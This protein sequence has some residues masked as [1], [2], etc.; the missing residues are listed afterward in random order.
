[1][2]TTPPSHAGSSGTIPGRTNAYLPPQDDPLGKKGGGNKGGGSGSGS[3]SGS[4]GGSG[5]RGSG[6]TGGVK[7]DPGPGR[8][9]GNSGGGY[10]GG[11]RGQSGGNVDLGKAGSG[12]TGTGTRSGGDIPLGRPDRVGSRSGNVGYGG[13]HNLG[14]GDGHAVT[15][16]QMPIIGSKTRIEHE[17]NRENRVK[18]GDNRYRNGYYN[19]NRGWHDNNFC[20]P[21]YGFQYYDGC[22]YA[23]SPFYFYY[24]LPAYVSC[25]RISIGFLTWTSCSTRYDWRR[26]V[27]DR[28]E[29]SYDRR[30]DFDYAVDD[31]ERA[32]E[33]RSMRLM[34]L[35]IP[36]NGRI[37]IDVEGQN[38]YSMSSADFYDMMKDLVEG[39][40]TDAYR[41]QNVYRDGDRGSIE[42]VHEYT[43]AWGRTQYVRQTF[44]LKL[45]RRGYEIC[46]F[47]TE[48]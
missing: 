34:S 41:I 8:G 3:G 36:T 11:S 37:E 35:L 19:S 22:N 30:A 38:Q 18:V 7:T 42:A 26:P 13:D 23:P 28:Y 20:Y 39:T 47:R 9:N 27:Y 25:T 17:V 44:G 45:G 46:Y 40:Q 16:G 43:D 5:S 48:G 14:R 10:G 29:S 24:H 6:S 1:M 4:G 21:Y 12:R 31:I 2:R 33:S 32:F 15:I